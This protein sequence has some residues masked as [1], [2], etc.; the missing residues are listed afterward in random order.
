MGKMYPICGEYFLSVSRDPC[1]P[2]ANV[3][4]VYNTNVQFYFSF[5]ARQ[6]QYQ[7][8]SLDCCR[9]LKKRLR[10]ISVQVI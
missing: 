10:S 1:C 9:S 4:H 2:V 7:K 5:L 3:G 6:L 8:W